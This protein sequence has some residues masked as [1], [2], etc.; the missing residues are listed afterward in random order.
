MGE[1]E[2]TEEQTETQSIS[3]DHSEQTSSSADN[4]A[5]VSSDIRR[6]RTDH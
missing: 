6:S 2:N 1:E 5:I 3:E 4:L